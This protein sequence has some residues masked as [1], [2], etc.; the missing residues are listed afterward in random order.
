MGVG[1]AFRGSVLRGRWGGQVQRGPTA[2][3]L[4]AASPARVP[5]AGDPRMRRS[6]RPRGSPAKGVPGQGLCSGRPGRVRGH[7][8]KWGEVG[9]GLNM[10]RAL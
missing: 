8:V 4:Q 7:G 9:C 6:Q 5:P 3:D 10:D 1:P 2:G